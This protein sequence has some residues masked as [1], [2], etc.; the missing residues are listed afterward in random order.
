MVL[1]G[2][3][4]DKNIDSF[5]KTSLEL[6]INYLLDN[7]YFILGSMSFRQLTGIPVGSDQAPFM[8]NVKQRKTRPSGGSYFLKKRLSS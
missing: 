2:L 3:T 5:N 6:G 8:E 7:Y 4:I 1:V